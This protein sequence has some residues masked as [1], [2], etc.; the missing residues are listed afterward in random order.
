MRLPA[1]PPGRLPARPRGRRAL[2]AKARENE[3]ASSYPRVWMK[4]ALVERELGDVAKE[5]AL[6]EVGRGGG[7]SGLGE[8]SGRGRM[9][10]VP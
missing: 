5:R 4:S 9:A 10:D 2:L 3:A 6:L 1:R 8:V 7:M